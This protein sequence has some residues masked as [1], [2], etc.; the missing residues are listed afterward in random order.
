M[1]LKILEAKTKEM[2]IALPLN[3]GTTVIG[4]GRG[5]QI[6]ISDSKLSSS[7]IELRFDGKAFYFR[8]LD[9][10]SGCFLNGQRLGESAFEADD[11][12]LIGDTVLQVSRERPKIGLSARQ[13]TEKKEVLPEQTSMKA[14]L[15][16]LNQS[17]RPTKL[18]SQLLHHLVSMLS[19]QRG[20]ILL[21]EK[22]RGG[23]VPVASHSIEDLEEFISLSSTVYESALNKKQTIVIED[24]AQLPPGREALSMALYETPRTIV[25]TPLAVEDEPFGVLYLDMK[26]RA[27][28]IPANFI[29]V[30]ETGAALAASRLALYKT[31]WRLVAAR[32]KAVALNSLA[33]ENSQMILG[34]GAV[35]RQLRQAIA[36]AASQDTTV[37]ILGDTGTGKEVV[38]RALHHAS[39]RRQEAFV[40]VNCAA[41]PRELLEA[42]LFGAEKGAYTGATERRL[43]RFELANGG[44]LFLDEIGELPQDIQVRLLRVLQ[45]RKL[46]RLG[47]TEDI[48]LDFRLVC[49]TNRNL[50]DAI[51]EGTFRSDFYYRINV[52]S[53]ELKPLAERKEDIKLLAEHF[54]NLFGKQFGRSFLGFSE[55]AERLLLS[56]QW[57]GNIRELRNAIERAAVIERSSHITRESLPI[58][59]DTVGG[60]AS[61]AVDGQSSSLT[62]TPLSF[63]AA[64]NQF[65]RAFLKRSLLANEGNVAAVV[66]ETGIGRPTIYRW[67]KRFGLKTDGSDE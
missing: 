2:K 9:S 61:P 14:L 47:G 64:R 16:G 32:D 60:I 54:L 48:E 59:G 20:F 53:I 63:D 4:R 33:W 29:E 43:G 8:D 19:A 5:S 23:L 62:E 66:R 27:D 28:G 18:L 52:F 12:M 40:A 56:Y 49:A 10:T 22:A 46:Q 65:E 37:L 25:C 55:D 6:I 17:T 36:A 21:R 11:E 34:D 39:S 7:H 3:E 1:W 57:P 26:R 31:R 67:L 30:L 24:T 50:E 58:G 13:S 38:A 44:T 42:E 15:D 45:E 51:R 41:L 35:S